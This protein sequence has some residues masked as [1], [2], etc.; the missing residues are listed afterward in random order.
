MARAHSIYAVE[1]IFGQPVAAFTVKHECKTYL[2]RHRDRTLYINV[3]PDGGGEPRLRS[4]PA[5]EFLDQ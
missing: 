1:N 5:T 3:I 2:G 4:V